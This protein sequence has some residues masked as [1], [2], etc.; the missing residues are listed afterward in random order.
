[1][2]ISRTF[3]LTLAAAALSVVSM[4]ASAYTK[5]AVHNNT[6]VNVSGEIRYAGCRSDRYLVAP[7][8]TFR[9]TSNRGHCLV[10]QITGAVSG[11]ARVPNAK[12]G[13]VQA[14][15]PSA[16]GQSEFFVRDT[17]NGY[18]IYSAAER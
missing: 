13:P 3:V 6:E 14:F 5:V 7:G 11:K 17:G 4:S 9:Q 18:R 8:A 15:T 16:T 12:A 2:K 10:I 1:M